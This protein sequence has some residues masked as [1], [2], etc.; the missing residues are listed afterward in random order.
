M[1]TILSGFKIAIAWLKIKSFV[2]VMPRFVCNALLRDAHNFVS[3]LFV[4]ALN[5]AFMEWYVIAPR[6]ISQTILGIVKFYVYELLFFY[7]RQFSSSPASFY[8]THFFTWHLGPP[9]V[10]AHADYLTFTCPHKSS[11]LVRLVSSIFPKCRDF[12]PSCLLLFWMVLVLQR[13]T[14]SMS[15]NLTSSA[16][17]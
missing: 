13:L 15:F 16:F 8:F 17:S 1:V 10:R 9:R 12:Y 5:D 14:P 2:L 4:V 7:T 11:G 3:L 6:F